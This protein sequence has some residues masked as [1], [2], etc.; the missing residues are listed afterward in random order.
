MN[1]IPKLFPPVMFR[2][3]EFTRLSLI[4]TR[5]F[6]TRDLDYSELQVLVAETADVYLPEAC[7]NSD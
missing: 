6:V 3:E 4:N 7:W 1:F 5:D 2:R